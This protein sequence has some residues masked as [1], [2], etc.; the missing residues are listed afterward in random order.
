MQTPL[1]AMDGTVGAGLRPS[2]V[3]QHDAEVQERAGSF[4]YVVALID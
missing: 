3:K 2:A 1:A 4:L